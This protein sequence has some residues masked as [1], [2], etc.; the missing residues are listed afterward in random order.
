MANRRRYAPHAVQ[1]SAA[2]VRRDAACGAGANCAARQLLPPKSGGAAV[3]N[4][5]LMR[6]ARG[7]AR[8]DGIWRKCAACEQQA[9]QRKALAVSE[10]D[11]PQEQ[12]ADYMA[13]A[14]VAGHDAPTLQG[15]PGSPVIQRQARAPNARSGGGADMA[16]TALAQVASSGGQE[17]EAATRQPY[18]RFLG[19]DLSAVRI[20]D[21]K[22]GRA[23]V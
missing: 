20:H 13:D 17:L 16:D 8:G 12:E 3:D 21:N 7:T 1:R 6:S 9:V 18:E 15:A 14:F 19:A 23:H 4:Q 2:S 10:P 5:S 11:D 22:I